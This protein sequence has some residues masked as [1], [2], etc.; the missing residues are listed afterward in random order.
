MHSHFNSILSQV[1][2][3]FQLKMKLFFVAFLALITTTVAV[4]NGFGFE[5][6]GPGAHG[7]GS[8]HFGSPYNGALGHYHGAGPGFG[9]VGKSF[10]GAGIG[11]R[12]F[13]GPSH[14]FGFENQGLG[15]MRGS[16]VPVYS[17]YG[18]HSRFASFGGHSGY[19]LGKPIGYAGHRTLGFGGFN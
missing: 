1:C 9:S 6:F 11:H 12:S 10:F 13:G 3:S 4:P 18:T 8:E 15:G 5:H 17:P 2:S 19:E 16:Y 14:R 7:F